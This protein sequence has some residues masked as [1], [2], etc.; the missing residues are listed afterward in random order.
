MR[1]EVRFRTRVVTARSVR[2]ARGLN[3]GGCGDRDLM[4]YNAR[5][6]MRPST[7][8]LAC[9]WV[10]AAML[11]LPLQAQSSRDSAGVLVID[12]TRPAWS[13]SERL[14]L[15]AKPHL[16]FGNN[17]DSA[18]R[19]RQVRGVTLMTDGRIAVA[20]GGSL[21]LRLFSPQGQLI[22]VNAGKGI[23]PGQLLNMHFLRRLPGDTLAIGAGYSTLALYSSTGQFARTMALPVGASPAESNGIARELGVLPYIE[24]EQVASQP[25]PPWLSAVGVFAAG[26]DRFYAGFGDRYAIRVYTAKGDLQSIIRR[27]WTPVPVTSDDWEHWV[28]EWSKLWVKTTGAERERDV[29]KVREE[30][31]ADVLPAF[32]QF[33]VDR[34]G[35]LWVREAH[36]Q[37]AIGAGSLTDTPAV[38]S[39]WSVFDV[40]G[41]WLGDVT[42]PIGFQPFEIGT[43]YVTGMLRTDGVNQV[44]IYSLSV[45][46]R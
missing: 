6:S 23:G 9:A 14:L 19:F 31:Y 4:P 41:R 7:I 46:G 45:R 5:V 27:A 29:Q 10:A 38:P 21:Q 40:R 3:A 42:M 20:D 16:V 35:R 13:D 33:I 22:S 30:P 34:N 25:M 36:W 24:L 43:D 26:D 39:N 28:V 1:R 17:T 32:S 12:N 8:G 2:D 44:V 18:Y 37:D 15:A 11:A